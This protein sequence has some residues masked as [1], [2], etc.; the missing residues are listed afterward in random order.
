MFLIA[1]LLTIM[2]FRLSERMV[3]YEV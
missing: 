2:V 1:A 3:Y